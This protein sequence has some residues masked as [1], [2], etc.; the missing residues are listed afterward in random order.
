MD[1]P[2]RPCYFVNHRCENIVH[3]QCLPVQPNEKED[4][5]RNKQEDSDPIQ[6][7]DLF[8]HRLTT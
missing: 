1:T 8:H 5:S 4:L 2:G 6:T 3:F 7:L